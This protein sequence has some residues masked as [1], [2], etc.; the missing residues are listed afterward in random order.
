[1]KVTDVKIR[2]FFSTEPLKAICSIT[3]DDYIVIH[4][5]KI[6]LVKGKTIVAMPS[7]KRADGTYSD[8][9]HPINADARN[10]IEQALL[11]KYH[12]YKDAENN[13]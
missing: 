9:V 2:K 8:I 5:V 4:D 3:L 7:R 1:M 11:E 12:E 13:Y 10:E 6:I